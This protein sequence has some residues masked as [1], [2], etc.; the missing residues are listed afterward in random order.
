MGNNITEKAGRNG[1][2]VRAREE[3]KWNGMEGR[4]VGRQE[5]KEKGRASPNGKGQERG[6]E[7]R[8]EGRND[9]A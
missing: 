9:R 6:R 7:G 3:W 8:K 1:S 5:W 4:E 2:R